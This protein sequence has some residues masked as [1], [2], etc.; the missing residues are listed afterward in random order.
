[1]FARKVRYQKPQ[2]KKGRN[3]TPSMNM[4]SPR[5]PSKTAPAAFGILFAAANSNLC[6]IH[7]E[8]FPVRFS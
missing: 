5:Y 7:P 4:L 3:P 6:Q 1:M 2:N 8:N